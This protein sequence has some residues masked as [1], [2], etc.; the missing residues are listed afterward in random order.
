MA[1]RFAGAVAC[2]LVIAS[3]AAPVAA[4]SGSTYPIVDPVLRMPAWTLSL[5]PG[6]SATGTML[7]PP[8][9]NSGTT[10]VFK[11]TSADGRTG[12]YFLPRADWAWGV[13]V[14]S[15]GDCLPFAKPVA[16]KDFIAYRLRGDGMGYV[17][18]LPAPRPSSIPGWT[19]DTARVLARYV[20]GTQ[21]FDAVVTATVMCRQQTAP[22]G[23]MHACSALSTRWFGPV[24]TVVPAT[25]RFESLKLTLNQQ[26][27]SAWTAAMVQ[28]TRQLYG[29]ETQ[30]LL[31]QGE[32][33]GQA[34]M[35]EHQQFM[36]AQQQSADLRTERFNAQENRKQT[37]T[38]NVVDHVLDCTRVYSNDNSVRVSGANCPNRQSW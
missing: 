21:T 11:A 13:G 35:Q 1:I 18:T 34:R 28:H 19:V 33:A 15:R 22:Y 14:S 36:A 30:A 26:W 23:T 32:L 6:W 27:M 16:A 2:A 4:A 29:A 5:P 25:P 31:R 20:V 10:P 8:S 24:G 17:S 12:A 37:N 7:P 3:S 38:D 9:C